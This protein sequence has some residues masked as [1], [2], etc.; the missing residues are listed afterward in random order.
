M[1][2]YFCLSFMFD[3]MKALNDVNCSIKTI[4]DLFLKEAYGKTHRTPGNGTFRSPA[5]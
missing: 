4:N 5:D 2:K 1:I 3:N